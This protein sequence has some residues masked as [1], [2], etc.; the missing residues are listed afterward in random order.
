MADPVNNPV[1]PRYYPTLSSVVSPE[2]IPDILG[3][4]KEGILSLFD[5]I[6]Y[7]DLQYN[8]SARGDAAF[9]NLSIVSK[10]RIGIEIPGTGIFLVLNPDVSDV[11]ISS[12][13]I[14]VAYEWKILGYLRAFNLENFSFNAQAI[15]ELAMQVLNVSENQAVA[16]FINTFVE[17]PPGSST[18]PLTQFVN[19]V[20]ATYGTT[21]TVPNEFTTIDEVISEMYEITNQYTSL[22]AFGVY[23]LDTGVEETRDKLKAYFN[24]LLPADIEEYIKDLLLPKVKAT[25]QL[26]AGVEFPRSILKPVYDEQGVNP[27]D[28]EGPL[29]EPLTEV[30]EVDDEGNPKVLLSFGEALFYAD[31]E[32]GLGYNLDIV[33]NTNFPAQV[34]N[35]G[36]IIDIKNLKIDISTTE[37]IIEADEDNRPPEFMGVYMERTDIFLPKKWFKKETGQ[38]LVISGR[39]LLIGTGGMSGTIAL[40]ATHAMQDDVVTDYFSE[41]FSFNYPLTVLIN[42]TETEIPDYPALLA[43][44]NTLENPSEPK[45]QYPFTITAPDATIQFSE[46]QQFFNYINALNPNKF[47]W[48]QLGS[49]PERAWKIGFDVFDLTFHHGQVIESN[50]HA[51]LEI[52]KFKG[53]NNPDE[54]LL[55]DLVGHWHSEDDFNLTAAF[56]PS[57]LPINLFNFVTINLLTAEVGRDEGNFFIGTSCQLSFSN[58]TMNKILGDQIIEIPQLRIYDNGSIE[59]IGGNGFI[60]V[61]IS[62]DLGPVE[63]AVSGIHY[64]STQLEH[65]DEMRTYN[66]WGFDGAISLDPLGLDARGEGIK[67]YY[68]SDNDE[69]GDEGDSFL[70]IQTIEVDLIIPGTADADTALAII[71]GEISLPEPGVSAEYEGEV[72][73][74]LPKARISGGAA[75]KLQPKYPAFYLEAGLDLPTPIPLGATGLGFYSFGGLIG[76]NY[77]TDKRTVGL[78]EEDSWY[79][80]FKHP[81]IGVN[82]E[83]FRT[84]DELDDFT[85]AFSVGAGTVLATMGDD[86]FLFSTRLMAILSLPSVFILDGRANVLGDRLGMLDN[87]EPPFFAFVA[88]GDNSLEFGFGADYKLQKTNGAILELYAEAQA[89]FFFNN[90]NAWYINFGTR[91]QPNTARLFKDIVNLEVQAYLMLSSQGMEA[92]ARL[93]WEFRKRF[94]PARVRAYIYVEVG[95]YIS[96]ERPQIG[97]YLAIG[98]G[99]E[100]DIWIISVSVDVNTMIAAE[101]PKPFLLYGTLGVEGCIKIPIIGRVCKSFTVELKWE[102]DKEVDRSAIPPLPFETIETASGNETDRTHELVKGIHMM[103]NEVF[104]LNYTSTPPSVTTVNALSADFI[105]PLDTYIDFKTEKALVPSAVSGS[106]KPI[107]GYTHAPE[108][109]VELIPPNRTVRGGREIRQVRHEYSI[110]DVQIFAS[111]DESGWQPYHPFKAVVDEAT[112]STVNNFKVGYWQ[113]KS[114][115]YDTIRLLATTPFTYMEA[116]EPGWVIPELLGITPSTLYCVEEELTGSCVDVLN[117][118]LGT[119]YYIPDGY[120]AHFIN[121]IYVTLVGE[122]STD[123]NDEGVSEVDGDFFKVTNETNPHG[124]SKSVSINNYNSLVLITP[125]PSI[126]IKLKLATYAAGVTIKYYRSVPNDD[127]IETDYQLVYEEYKTAAQLNSQITY[128]NYVVPISKVVIEPNTPDTA[129]INDLRE[130]IAALFVDTYGDAMG[131]VSISEPSDPVLYAQLVAQLEALKANVCTVIEGDPDCNKDDIL[132]EF[133]T[134]LLEAY[135]DCFLYPIQSINQLFEISQ[136]LLEWDGLIVRFDEINPEYDLIETLGDVYQ[137]MYQNPGFL[138]KLTQLIAVLD[139]YP[140]N[141]WNENEVIQLYYQLIDCAEQILQIIADLGNCHC[142]DEDVE[143]CYTSLQEVCWLTLEEHLY[144]ETIPDSEAIAEEHQDMVDGLSKVAQP[145]W[146]PNTSYYIK[147]TLKDTVDH[148]ENEGIYNHYYSFKTAGPLGHFHKEANYVPSGV[149]ADQYPI[150]SLRSY[151]DYNRSYPNADGSLLKAKPLF[152]GHE[153][154]KIGLFFNKPYVNHMF[155]NWDAYVNPTNDDTAD[156]FF[157]DLHIAIK[158]PVTDMIIPYPLPTEYHETVPEPTTTEWVDDQDPQLPEHIQVINNMIANGELNCTIDLGE[159][160]VPLSQNYEVSYTNLKPRKLYTALIYNAFGKDQ[161]DQ[162]SEKVHEYVFQTSRYRNFEEQVL[163]YRSDDGEQRQAAFFDIPVNVSAAEITEAFNLVDYLNTPVDNTLETAYQHVFDRVT[164]GVLGIVPIDPPETTEFNRVINTNTG[165]VIGILIKSPEPFNNPKIPLEVIDGSVA[166]QDPAISILNTGSTDGY[167]VLYSKDYA[168]AFIMHTSKKITLIS[169]D[170]QF[171]YKVWNGSEHVVA[172]N[173]IAGGI[174]INE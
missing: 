55:I 133:Y 149:N 122:T 121:G 45:L 58:E 66:Y 36:L 136:C 74:K 5:N 4:I 161:N 77:V 65:N 135:H 54:D 64:G 13:P 103:T 68:T 106:G 127:V 82:R 112:R 20:N 39:K 168:Q 143:K 111:Y 167:R 128:E 46:E 44:V 75:M 174:L 31:T 99:A 79:D 22:I 109:H 24:S 146:R 163:S 123:P 96:F 47:M 137:D 85:S 9:Y 107:G 43:H 37:N 40:R 17:V 140:E 6:H 124:F 71:H 157:G 51:Q 166:Q 148:G 144:N 139:G 52:P 155:Q 138:D 87:T 151:I 18:A 29:G 115:Q 86:G 60:P 158:D 61:N 169:L 173:V 62:L 113:K 172:G 72:S 131:E 160:I 26:S 1:T 132:C 28:P 2:D 42:N 145:I 154:A 129:A 19:D 27:V 134:T 98:G 130:Q 152:Y 78:T 53:V 162:V 15:F 33:L 92:G 170:I 165:D 35:T 142:T 41:Y 16:H 14:T 101:V 108:N 34:G 102:I 84:P 25:L 119:T 49:N 11:Q 73:F 3:F 88:I 120:I 117:K 70:H 118:V 50:L 94:G 48:F 110:E 21:V 12:L 90:G 171:L 10:K 164:E 156:S 91:E 116:G 105:L 89:G 8:K 114:R 57:G 81:Q 126:E 93:D 76:Y 125:E 83:K 80:Y 141:D 59:I 97:G 159:P 7:K 23:I 38:T 30:P 95:G 100:V 153:E 69:Y 104:N 63:V 150:T 32:T 147:Y 67:Y 56:L